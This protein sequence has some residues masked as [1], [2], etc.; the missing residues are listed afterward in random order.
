MSK[1]DQKKAKK[2]Q[3]S[4]PKVILGCCSRMVS[5]INAYCMKSGA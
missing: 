1:K 5:I 4:V 3:F 2:L